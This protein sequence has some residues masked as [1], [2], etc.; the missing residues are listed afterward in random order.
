MLHVIVPLLIIFGFAITL[1]RLENAGVRPL[2][3]TGEAKTCAGCSA[4]LVASLIF[5]VFIALP[6]NWRTI[7]WSRGQVEAGLVG[8][9]PP[10]GWGANQAP[11]YTA[12]TPLESHGIYFQDDARLSL[13]ARDRAQGWILVFPLPFVLLLWLYDP[14]RRVLTTLIVVLIVGAIAR[15]AST[16]PSARLDLRV[17][18]QT[19][20]RET[21]R[22]LCRQRPNE[23]TAELWSAYEAWDPRGA[24][25]VAPSR[26]GTFVRCM[27]IGGKGRLWVIEEW[28]RTLP[29][30]ARAR[31]VRRFLEQFLAH[32]YAARALLHVLPTPK[33]AEAPPPLDWIEF[34]NHPAIPEPLRPALE[35]LHREWRAT[36][37]A[38][39]ADEASPPT[40][41]TKDE[42]RHEDE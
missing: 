3:G 10:S 24:A 7:I 36:H 29:D 16:A 17:E 19:P 39:L 42:R 9:A 40:E 32:H 25:L 13:D 4:A 2:A 18:I 34:V 41:E 5:F 6:A 37:L 28:D 8:P 31:A 26:D 22:E 27:V 35:E 30:Y 12:A 15:L 23:L 20:T 33:S 14:K 21:C 1:S 38:A 11:L